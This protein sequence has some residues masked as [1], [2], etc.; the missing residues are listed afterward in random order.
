[1][2]KKV[3]TIGAAVVACLGLF[4]PMAA[5]GNLSVSLTHLTGLPK[6]LYLA[7]PAVLAL[8][9]CRKAKPFDG[10]HFWLAGTAAVAVLLAVFA[11][12][13]AK[14]TLEAVVDFQNTGIN[15][16]N[17]LG[18][19]QL[20]VIKTETSIG[21][22]FVMIMAGCLAAALVAWWDSKTQKNSV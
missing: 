17:S 5:A 10:D 1:M 15:A 8:A 12:F 18:G 11:L 9:I 6:A 7:V 4:L 19:Q 21:W 16:L 2:D 14:N 13:G 20:E 3:V 22:G